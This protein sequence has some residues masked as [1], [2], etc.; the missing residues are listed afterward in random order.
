MRMISEEGRTG[1]LEFLLTAPVTDAAVVAGKFLAAATFMALLWTAP[2]AYAAAVGLAGS[3]NDWGLLV[4][5]WLGALLCSALFCA[6]G[7]LASSW[8]S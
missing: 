6:S 3:P 5:R 8:V 7:L 2:F 4:S 1:I